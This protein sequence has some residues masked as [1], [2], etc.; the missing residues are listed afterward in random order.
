MLK[1][2]YEDYQRYK[3]DNELNNKITWV[4]DFKTNQPKKVKWRDLKMGQICKVLKNEEV[5]AD[6]LVVCAPADIVYIS[7]MNL[8]GETNL[9]ER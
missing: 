9:K 7:T 8:D 3:S 6:L 5:P 4:H 1:E 2:A